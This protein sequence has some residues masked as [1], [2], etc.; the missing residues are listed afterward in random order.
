MIIQYD[1]CHILT[2]LNHAFIAIIEQLTIHEFL[3][4]D[5][6]WLTVIIITNHIAQPLSIIIHS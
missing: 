2:S 1:Y 6:Y 4:D 5:H 3:R